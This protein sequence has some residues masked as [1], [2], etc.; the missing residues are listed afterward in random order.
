MS[1]GSGGL[2]LDVT[3]RSWALGGCRPS[4]RSI[5]EAVCWRLTQNLAM[6]VLNDT[7]VVTL[8]DLQIFQKFGALVAVDF[9]YFS[10]ENVVLRVL[11]DVFGLSSTKQEWKRQKVPHLKVDMR[12]QGGIQTH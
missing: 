2:S 11:L 7:S 10:S 9:F 8:I 12:Y 6:P 4:N 5:R 3:C 1:P